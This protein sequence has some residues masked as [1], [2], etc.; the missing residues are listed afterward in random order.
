[1][2]SARGTVRWPWHFLCFDEPPN[3]A[4]DSCAALVR[5]AVWAVPSKKWFVVP[6]QEEV[7]VRA[8]PYRPLERKWARTK[9][10][11]RAGGLPGPPGVRPHNGIG[12]SDRRRR[13]EREVELVLAVLAVQ[14]FDLRSGVL[15]SQAGHD[16]LRPS[17]RQ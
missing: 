14:L 2:E 6:V 16:V 4:T 1:M 9:P 17:G 10:A 3:D 8:A 12:C 11:I 15:S 5:A 7:Q 13:N